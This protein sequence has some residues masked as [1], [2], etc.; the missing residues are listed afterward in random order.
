MRFQYWTVNCLV[1]S[2]VSYTAFGCKRGDLQTA[3][4]TALIS[5]C[6]GVGPVY[7]LQVSQFIPVLHPF[8]FAL[9]VWK[10][11]SSGPPGPGCS[12]MVFGTLF[13]PSHWWSS[14]YGT[15]M[16][17]VGWG[18]RLWLGNYFWAPLS[19][20]T[21]LPLFSQPGPSNYGFYPHGMKAKTK[22]LSQWHAI[23][24]HWNRGSSEKTTDAQYC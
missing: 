14:Y 7:F 24:D 23:T 3:A 4:T 17:P 15:L 12:S 5:G 2:L 13:S 10:W 9:L 19:C 6:V 8:A 21:K 18:W 1:F 20:Q 16:Q 11:H 22:N